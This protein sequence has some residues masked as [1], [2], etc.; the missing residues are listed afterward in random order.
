MKPNERLALFRKELALSE[1]DVSKLVG[2]DLP[3]YYDLEA[4]DDLQDCISISKLSALAHVMKVC[5]S[6]FFSDAQVSPVSPLSLA[7]SIRRTLKVRTIEL[8][9]FE[10]IVGWEI[11]PFIANPSRV[12]S[13]WNIECLQDVCREAGENWMAVLNGQA[14]E[15]G[16]AAAEPTNRT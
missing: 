13:E 4:F 11:A 5:P 8:K 7:N 1:E 15:P 3:S 12:I 10:E 9:D 14:M 6:E 2:I 16:G